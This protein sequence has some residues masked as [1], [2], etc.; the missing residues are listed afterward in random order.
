MSTIDKI[1]RFFFEQPRWVKHSLFWLGILLLMIPKELVYSRESPFEIAVMYC[2]IIVGQVGASYFFAY[3]VIPN[4]LWKRRYLLTVLF[5]ILGTYAF[6]VVERIMVVHVGETLVRTPP[7]VQ[8]PVWE[9]L[10]DWKKLL[11]GYIPA[12]YSGVVFFLLVKY[13]GEYKKVKERDLELSK[14]KARNE[15]KMLK[16]QLNPHFLFNT[17][18]NIYTLALS[19]APNTAESIGK[20]SEILDHVLYK[21]SGNWVL[22]SD[23]LQL[24]ANYISLERLRYDERL[25]IETSEQL[26]GD[27]EIPPLILL[28]L[29]ENAFKHGAGEDS[30]APSIHMHTEVGDDE[31]VFRIKNS[32]PLGY[33]AKEEGI[34]LTNITKQLDLV[35]AEAYE[36]DITVDRSYFEVVLTVKIDH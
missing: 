1:L 3:W 25:K 26:S 4:Y 27:V 22:L 10:T 31:F 29:V 30:G 28:S 6:S 19:N 33:Q 5:F 32:I 24:I 9:I 23:E 21:C 18:N 13:F 11:H 2:C 36:L 35:Y 12:L 14:E 16:A 7:F 34:G 20:L 17:L 15:L 8:E